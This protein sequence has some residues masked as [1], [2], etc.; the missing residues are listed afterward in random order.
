M[1]DQ[2]MDVDALEELLQRLDRSGEIGRVKLIYV[3]DYFQNPTGLT[4]SLARRQR[5]VALA[6]RYSRKHRI[7]IL[8]DAAY[9]ELRYEG[10]DLPSLKKFDPDNRFVV[11]TSTFSKPC[12]PGLKTGFGVLPRDLREPIVRLKGGHDFGSCNLAQHLL[13]RLM[14]TGTYQRH[15]VE[16][17]AAY[18]VKRDA[19]LTVLDQEFGNWPG[20]GWTR[21]A[22]GLYVWL[23]FPNRI[24]TG[25]DSPLMRAALREGVLYVPG[26]FCHVA[27]PDGSVPRHEARLCFGVATADQSRE[28]VRRLHKALV[29]LEHPRP[30]AKAPAPAGV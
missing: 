22:G 13:D 17:Q 5:L 24:E 23:R 25:P 21:P 15:V 30:A 12:A 6:E 10:D 27:G 19:L 26:E 4:L 29:G 11:W 9:R 18:R 7:L 8:E 20:M 2:G 14:E 28:A 16:L 1:D 3:Q